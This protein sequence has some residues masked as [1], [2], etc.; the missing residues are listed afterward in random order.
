MLKTKNERVYMLSVREIPVNLPD[1]L[2]GIHAMIYTNMTPR[3][4]ATQLN[5][6]IDDLP[7]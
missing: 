2:P 5:A 3:E 1:S 7:D 4:F 6:G